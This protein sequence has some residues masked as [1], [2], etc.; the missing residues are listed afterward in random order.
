LFLTFCDFEGFAQC[1]SKAATGRTKQTVKVCEAGDANQVLISTG[2]E[3][4]LSLLYSALVL[5]QRD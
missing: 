2:W 4:A 1:F 5:G 3:A